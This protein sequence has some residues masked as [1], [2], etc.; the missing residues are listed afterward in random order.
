LGVCEKVVLELLNSDMG[1][2]LGLVLIKKAK[3]WKV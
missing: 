3:A 1:F 2:I